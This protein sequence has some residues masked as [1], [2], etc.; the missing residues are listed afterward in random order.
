MRRRAGGAGLVRPMMMVCRVVIMMMRVGRFGTGGARPQRPQ[1]AAALVP[2]QPGA[3]QRDQRVA[4]D[5]DGALGAAHGLGGDVQQPRADADDRHR[6]Q[7]LQQ[8]RHQRQHDAAPGAFLIGDQIGRNHRLAVTGAGGMEHA[9]GK[10]DPD[11]GPDRAAIGFGGADRA[12]HLLVERRL[13]RQQ[14]ADH[15]ARLRLGR[16]AGR[17][18][19]W[20]GGERGVQRAIGDQTGGEQPAAKQ[21]QSGWR[22]PCADRDAEGGHRPSAT[23]NKAHGQVTAILLANIAP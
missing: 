9:I 14:P 7:R 4:G 3:K 1:Q 17:R 20:I 13:L 12:G 16:A 21:R 19:E 8:R 23:L 2:H 10:R 11:Q 6:H 15:A 18:A 5:L 22:P